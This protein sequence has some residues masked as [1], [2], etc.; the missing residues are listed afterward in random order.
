MTVGPPIAVSEQGPL[1]L[2]EPWGDDVADGP[3][4]A[5]DRDVHLLYYSSLLLCNAHRS[6]VRTCCIAP[7]PYRSGYSAE[8]TIAKR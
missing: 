3:T 1:I 6:S 4:G 2:L 5:A 8:S 7:R